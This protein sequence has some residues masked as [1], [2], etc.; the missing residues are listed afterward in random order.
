[1]GIRR[2]HDNHGKVSQ[3]IGTSDGLKKLDAADC[4]KAQVEKNG[5]QVLALFLGVGQV[6]EGPISIGDDPDLTVKLC[7]L[8]L[9]Q[10][11]SLIVRIVFHNE[12]PDG[13][14]G[15]HGEQP[16]LFHCISVWGED[17]ISRHRA[18]GEGSCTK[19][20]DFP[21]AEALSYLSGCRQAHQ[22]LVTKRH[23]VC[24]NSWDLSS[25]RCNERHIVFKL[26]TR[27]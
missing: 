27:R 6:I 2:S 15:F 23:A 26:A 4:G 14:G 1:M 21:L 10:K 8:K 18:K 25:P 12:N 5:N 7:V 9:T 11:Q 17:P 19:R 20:L 24:E 3:A 22:N 13:L 16:S